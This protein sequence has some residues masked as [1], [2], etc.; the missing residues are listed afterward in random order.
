MLLITIARTVDLETPGAQGQTYVV[1]D[2]PEATARY[3]AAV[4]LE[5]YDAAMRLLGLSCALIPNALLWP[6][7]LHAARPV[8]E[9]PDPLGQCFAARPFS[10][11][12]SAERAFQFG[13]DAVLLRHYEPPETHPFAD[14]PATGEQVLLDCGQWVL[15]YYQ[16]DRDDPERRDNGWVID[17]EWPGLVWPPRAYAPVPPIPPGLSAIFAL[18]PLAPRLP[19]TVAPESAAVPPRTPNLTAAGDTGARRTPPHPRRQR[20]A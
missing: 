13:A 11:H 12:Q 2:G 4:G 15:G 18:P 6:L 8:R 10:V 17:E 9:T 7:V 1:A 3:I 16:S 19:V 14:A 20:Q 5:G